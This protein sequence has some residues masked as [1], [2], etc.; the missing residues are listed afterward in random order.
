[1]YLR[2]LALA[3]LALPLQA[4]AATLYFSP[5]HLELETGVESTITLYA[6]AEAPVHAA[7]ADISY[8]PAVLRVVSV[9]TDGSLLTN[10]STKPTASGPLIRFSGW[11]QKA[12]T[13]TR[14]TLLSITV[15]PL[16]TGSTALEM[17]SGTLLSADVQENNIA[18]SLASASIVVSPHRVAAPAQAQSDLAPTAALGTTSATTAAS[19][20][21]DIDPAPP[22]EA[23]SSATTT[24][25]S[26][27]VNQ[28]ASVGFFASM[29]LW[30][31]LYLGLIILASIV[32]GAFIGYLFFR[33]G[34]VEG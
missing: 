1:M 28:A 23:T 14:G 17:K 32:L 4:S 21:T 26:Q 7:E 2:A 13:G 18:T 33:A 10:F 24:P 11:M 34:R 19:S 30:D 16:T 5:A 12:F 20:T 27:T 8:D 31:Y 25:G 15:V 6:D 3:F 22:L 9:S 29:A